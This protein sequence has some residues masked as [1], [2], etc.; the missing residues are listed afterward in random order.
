MDDKPTNE[1]P[2]KEPKK[3][4]NKLDLSQLQSFNFGTEWAKEKTEPGTGERRRDD[5]PR[6]DGPQDDRKDRRG[7][8]RSGN[9][10]AGDGGGDGRERRGGADRPGGG[11]GQQGQGRPR[12]G[13]PYGDRRGAPAAPLGPYISPHF[14]ATFYPEDVSFAALAKTIRSSART[15]ELFD[16]AKTVIGKHDRFVVVL[17]RKPGAA[18]TTEG[19]KKPFYVCLL[20]GIPFE[21]EEAAI[22]HVTQKH[23]DRFFAISEQE[24]EPPKGSF[25][26]I[27]KCGVTGDLLGPPNY[28][29]YTQMMQQHH[30]TRLARMD[31]ERFSS[32]IESVRDPEVVEAWLQ[33]MKTV[34][35]YTW[36]GDENVPVKPASAESENPAATES[37]PA[38]A[39]EATVTSTPTPAEADVA[40]SADVPAEAVTTEAETAETPA[41]ETPAV[42]ATV[43]ETAADSDGESAVESDTSV[44]AEEPVAK[45]PVAKAEPSFDSVSDAKV[46]LITHAREKC[47]RTY[48]HGRFHGRALADMPDGE[49]KQAVLG[50]LERQQRFPLDTANALR[51]RLRREGFTIF[52]KGSK[53]VS[54]VSAVKR[55]FRVAGQNFA[56]SINGLITFVETHPMVKVSELTTKFLGIAPIKTAAVEGETPTATAP[57]TVSPFGQTDQPRIK[58]MQLDLRWLVTEGYVT[59]FIDGSL[60]AAAPMPP[61]KPKPVA[62]S[63]APKVAPTES[64]AAKPES[65]ET[66]APAE[67]SKPEPESP[68]PA[69]AVEA[70]AAPETAPVAPATPEPEAAVTPPLEPTVESEPVVKAG[71]EPVVDAQPDPAP[72][73]G[74]VPIPEPKPEPE[75]QPE[76]VPEPQVEPQPQPEQI[77]DPAPAPEPKAADPE[78]PSFEPEKPE[79]KPTS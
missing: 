63:P 43:P 7:F 33:S 17:E 53:G 8:K 62:A 68:Q 48:E 75:T 61:P 60:F 29:R 66:P 30:A 47:V 26:V 70:V 64:V 18:T 15:F 41:A 25:Q 27:N 72:E 54:Y 23:M 78:S 49:I 14:D 69:P 74:L 13:G 36:M 1:V 12:P 5:R 55:K 67:A 59:E 40:V 20:D 31:F 22:N 58:R 52:K 34:T 9:S 32:R 45:A 42:D 73:P 37:K 79:S 46:Y 39:E 57:G 4:F 56:D 28:H 24:T 44:V 51:G 65:T 16:I 21:S 50:A 10:V 6:R 35:R 3:E 38:A 76:P 77:P 2:K 19:G 11:Q 71:P